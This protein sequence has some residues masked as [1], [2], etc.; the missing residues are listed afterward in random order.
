M[1]WGVSAVAVVPPKPPRRELDELSLARARRGDRHGAQQ[2]VAFYQRPIFAVISRILGPRATEAVVEELA[3]D[4]FLRALRALPRFDPDGSARVSTW[5]ITIASRVALTELGRKR[6]VVEPLPHGAE[7]SHAG[8]AGRVEARH[9]LER[10]VAE[11]TPQQRAVFVLRDVH[12]FTETETADA[13]T[14]EVDAVKSRLFRAR[15]RLRRV[16]DGGSL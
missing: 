16:L 6:A 1:K 8:D 2:F 14:L 7:P 13:L 12:G 4:A 11:L 15:A 9:A 5:L 3:Q 10:A